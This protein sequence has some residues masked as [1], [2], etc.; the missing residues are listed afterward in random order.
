MSKKAFFYCLFSCLL[1]GGCE[2][3]GLQPELGLNPRISQPGDDSSPSLAATG[4]AWIAP[5]SAQVR[6]LDF[7]TGFGSP[8]PGLNRPDAQPISVSVDSAGKRFALV[9]SLAGRTELLIY[10]RNL[11]L[12]RSIGLVPAGVPAKVAISGD[13]RVL[14]VQVSRGGRWQV[15]LLDLP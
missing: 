2:G 13:G 8:L 6:W 9:R 10:E 15:E 11:A 14:A 4:M 3:Q 12:L 1:L 7:S 5:G